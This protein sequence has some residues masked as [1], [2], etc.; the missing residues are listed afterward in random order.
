MQNQI[1]GSYMLP[2]DSLVYLPPVDA[3]KWS[4]QLKTTQRHNLLAAKPLLLAPETQMPAYDSSVN[5]MWTLARQIKL[6][7]H[8]MPKL[9]ILEVE[10]FFLRLMLAADQ[11]FDRRFKLRSTNAYFRAFDRFQHEIERLYAADRVP[12]KVRH[13]EV[14][15]PYPKG[16]L[17]ETWFKNKVRTGWDL[18]SDDRVYS[19]NKVF[20]AV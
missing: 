19:S 10:I 11:F 7:S 6:L 16:R 14:T 5:Y 15:W 4:K 1:E 13:D 20:Q 9:E 8:I 12:L 3:D 18:D 2:E 17:R